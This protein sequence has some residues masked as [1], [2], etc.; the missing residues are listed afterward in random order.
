MK[1]KSK[2]NQD[3]ELEKLQAFCTYQERCIKDVKEKLKLLGVENSHVNPIISKLQKEGFLNEER[4]A[5]SFAIGKQR[6]NKWGKMKIRYELYKKLIPQSTVEKA[7]SH[8]DKDE[9]LKTLEDIISKK[10]QKLKK[11]LEDNAKYKILRSLLTKGYEIELINK[12]LEA[13]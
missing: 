3:S 13:G 9:Y 4:Y 5:A 2:Y 11:P 12:I 6:N 7:I 8:I 1:K 10:T